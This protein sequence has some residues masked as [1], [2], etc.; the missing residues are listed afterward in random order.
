[1]LT[2]AALVGMALNGQGRGRILLQPSALTL[3][4]ALSFRAQ[5]V[6]VEVEVDGVADFGIKLLLG[7]RRILSDTGVRGRRLGG[8]STSPAGIIHRNVGRAGCQESGCSHSRQ[9]RK[10]H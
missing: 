2:G 9:N 8:A 3:Q 5:A 4:L 1:V 6:A 10:T 7:A